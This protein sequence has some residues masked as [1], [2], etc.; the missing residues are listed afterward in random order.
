MSSP[1]FAFALCSRLIVSF[2]SLLYHRPSEHDGKTK[3]GSD[4]KRMSSSH[5][6]G[7]DTGADPHEAGKK[8]G[9]ASY[10]NGGLTK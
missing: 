4:D 1:R 2:R 5:G 6:F 3:D 7:S 8:G 9:E 10:E